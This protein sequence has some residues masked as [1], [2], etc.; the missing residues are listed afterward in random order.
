MRLASSA[1]D[2]ASRGFEGLTRLQHTF[3]AEED[4]SLGASGVGA[5]RGPEE[6]LCWLPVEIE[7]PLVW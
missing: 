5:L 7:A 4:R 1:I 3:G 2:A 6:E